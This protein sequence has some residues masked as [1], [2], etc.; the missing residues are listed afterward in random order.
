[1]TERNL[2]QARVDAIRRLTRRRAATRLER[3]LAKSSPEDIAQ[4]ATHLTNQDTL[5]LFGHV[6]TDIAGEA[7]LTL[8]DEDLDA[9]VS[10]I[11]LERLV[12]WLDAME[13][14]DEADLIERL[15]DDLRARVLERIVDQDREQVEELLAWPPDSAG[16]I[17]SPVAF[18]LNE[19]TTCREAISALQ[20]Q[21]DVEMVF[22]LYV[23]NDAGQ[24]VGVAS[25]R[26]LLLN[27]PSSALGEIM[28]TEVISVAPETD[29]EEVA[30]L[31]SRYDF[32]AVPVVDDT[33]RL[34]GIV[35]IDDVL[36]VIR[37]EAAEDMLK[38]A[39]VAEAFDP[40]SGDTVRAAR[41]RLTWLM[42]TLMGGIGLSEV[43]GVF[44]TTLSRQA[45][46]A[47]FIPV[48]MGL[49]GNVGIQA[50]TITVRNLATGHV[51]AG[52]ASLGLLLRE[53]RVG[54][55]IGLVISFLLTAFCLVRYPMWQLGVAVGISILIAVMGS[56]VLGTL[57]PLT[58]DR[59]G[60]DPAVATGPFVTTSIDMTSIVIYFTIC[61][62]AFGF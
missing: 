16:G 30:R 2:V 28:A 61:T 1:M 50:A 38:M 8:T 49:S 34:L 33:H 36:D 53:G 43:I 56:A 54:L 42:V 39:G 55:L 46:L 37:E 22:Y 9:V 32:L 27:A 47:G 5:F 15:P 11:P 52:R 31:A 23:E 26:N 59:F 18:R 3:A 58:L 60:V 24:L 6:D 19:S 7:L 12:R 29:Q 21:G 4:A 17:M 40:H 10:R 45:V 20:E 48:V 44:E 25:L 14:D 62:V 13:H 35:T 41:Q 57:I 51:M